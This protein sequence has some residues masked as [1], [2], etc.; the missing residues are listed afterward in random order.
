MYQLCIESWHP[1]AS[2]R[3]HASVVQ[4]VL[5]RELQNLES[6]QSVEFGTVAEQVRLQK[7]YLPPDVASNSGSN[8]VSQVPPI[9][10]IPKP[11]GLEED[12]FVP[13]AN[14]SDLDVEGEEE[15]VPK[16][17]TLNRQ[18]RVFRDKSSSTYI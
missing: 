10:E 5:H 9:Y 12:F 3:P 16:I 2:Q 14:T 18:S 7:A 17:S 6:D 15:D 8:R 4:Q 13:E 1:D 11:V